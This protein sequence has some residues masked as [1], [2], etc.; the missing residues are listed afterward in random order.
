MNSSSNRG[1]S[2]GRAR[3]R[4]AQSTCA[5]LHPDVMTQIFEALEQLQMNGPPTDPDPIRHS[6]YLVALIIDYAKIVSHFL[7]TLCRNAVYELSTINQE[8]LI[9]DIIRFYSK[10]CGCLVSMGDTLRDIFIRSNN[11]DVAYE[12]EKE[13]RQFIKNSNHYKPTLAQPPP[14]PSQPSQK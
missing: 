2:H 7:P 11:V 9:I 14:I 12:I 1:N 3:N 5:P 13:V 8:M 6:N 4:R 10:S